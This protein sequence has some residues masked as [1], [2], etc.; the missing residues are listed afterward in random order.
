MA[1]TTVAPG[2]G[3]KREA[4]MNH[5][6]YYADYRTHLKI[7]FVGLFFAALVAGVGIFARVD[8][9]DLGTAP[10]VKATSSTAVTGN[11]RAIR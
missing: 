7:I 2:P 9:L 10:L 8:T 6:I 5:L 4:E 3:R 1:S 11:F